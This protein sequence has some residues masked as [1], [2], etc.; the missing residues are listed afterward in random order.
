MAPPLYRLLSPSQTGVK[1]P[2]ASQLPLLDIQSKIADA[3]T[4]FKGVDIV[5][6]YCGLI[7][8]I[9]GFLAWMLN[10]KH[11]PRRAWGKRLFGIGVLFFLI[12]VN[13]SW[14][15]NLVSYVLNL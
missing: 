4:K 6:Y 13:F 15:Y 12:G 9:L 1:P 11:R 7:L 10:K 8:I 2:L 14:F 3:L 5:M